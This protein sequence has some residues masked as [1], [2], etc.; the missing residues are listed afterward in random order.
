VVILRPRG[1]GWDLLALRPGGGAG[2]HAAFCD[3]ERD[4]AAGVARQVLEALA[5][6]AGAGVNPVETVAGPA[7]NNYRLCM[8]AVGLLWLACPRQPGQPYRPAEFATLEEARDAATRL[9]RF[10]CPAPDADQEFY[11]NTQNF[12]R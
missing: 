9:A 12:S 2:P 5:Q 8:R 7:H 4:E 11:F 10:V 6:G 3:F 1:L